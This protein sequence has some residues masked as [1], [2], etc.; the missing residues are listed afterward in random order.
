M[1]DLRV[2]AVAG[3]VL[4]AT[5]VVPGAVPADTDADGVV[6]FYAGI[7]LLLASIVGAAGA[8]NAAL[9]LRRT[10]PAVAA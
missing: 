1:R 8:W 3:W 9:G 2:L 4:V 5:Q 6:G 10:V 7:A